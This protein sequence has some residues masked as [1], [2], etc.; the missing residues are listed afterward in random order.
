MFL[1]LD[2][3]SSTPLVGEPDR[4]LELLAILN[5]YLINEANIATNGQELV[6][7]FAKYTDEAAEIF[8]SKSMSLLVLE[9]NIGVGKTTL[10]NKLVKDYPQK[11]V[12]V[13]EPLEFWHKILVHKPA[14]SPNPPAR[15][16]VFEEFY[17]VLTGKSSKIIVF[18]FQIIA[19]YSRLSY[20]V[21]F[22]QNGHPGA[23]LI[24]ER[25]FLSDRY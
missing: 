18:I 20:L 16:N 13:A 25:S 10:L 23:L 12:V 8:A 24:S 7:F 17:Q 4:T 9:G 14:E 11:I 21:H 5:M 15:N 2:P 6:K 3:E 19:L 1:F 22:Y